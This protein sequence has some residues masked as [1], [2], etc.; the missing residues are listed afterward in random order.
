MPTPW[1]TFAQLADDF[2]IAYAEQSG[3]A[4]PALLFTVG[5][6]VELY[7][8]STL[9]HAHPSTDV[10]TH[11]H[12]VGSMLKKVQVWNPSLLD[13]YKL[14]PSVP[15]KFMGS[16]LL[17]LAAT[18]DPE[19]EHYIRHQELYWVAEYLADIKYLGSAHKKLPGTFA[20]M[21]CARNPYWVPFFKELRA[22]LG[23]PIA[24]M[25]SDPIAHYLARPSALPHARA[26]LAQ[27]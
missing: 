26:W 23:W 27:L 5:H 10:T 8:K 25:W 9:L 13:T 6:S 7:L 18:A 16:P 11:G 14:L 22:Y 19:Y 1:Q 20:V 24:G 4:T 3:A 12:G 2:L 17:P 15:G 21:T